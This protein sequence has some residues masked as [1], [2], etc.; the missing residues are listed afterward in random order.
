MTDLRWALGSGESC[1]LFF[2]SLLAPWCWTHTNMNNSSWYASS[3]EIRF[4]Q[5]GTG[6]VT[7]SDVAVSE[8]LYDA[9]PARSS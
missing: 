4:F 5:D 3:T 9:W 2:L 8:G 1:R 6:N 7:Y